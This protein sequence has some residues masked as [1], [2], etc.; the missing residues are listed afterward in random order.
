MR[1]EKK[2]VIFDMDG[3]VVHTG[4]QHYAA[5]RRVF[6]E[7]GV[8]FGEEEFRA[9]FGIRNPE[10][11]RRFLGEELSPQKVEELGERKEDYYRASVREAGLEPAPGFLTLLQELKRADFKIALGTSGPQQNVELIVEKLGL[12]HA[13]DA[14]VTG[15]DVKRGKP[16]PDTFLLAAERCGVAPARCVVVEDAPAGLAAAKRAGM[17]AIGVTGTRDREALTEA[18]LVVDSLEKVSVALIQRLLR[19]RR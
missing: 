9:T 8:D 6:A 19:G 11:L 14:V 13:F 4:V 1:E 5:W 2:A 18:D 12:H 10:I 15:A 17:A 16:H 3:V 7:E